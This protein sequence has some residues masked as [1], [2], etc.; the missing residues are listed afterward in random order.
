MKHRLSPAIVILI[1][2]ASAF[3][4]WQYLPAPLPQQWTTAELAT[5]QSL[6]LQQ[7]PP[8]PPDPSNRFADHPL[9]IEFGRQLFFDTRLSSN[10]A[11]SCA[12]CH[13]P[14]R[15]F[16]DGRA[17]A[18]GIGSADRNSMGLAG[19]AYSPWLFWDGRKDSLWSQA[20]EPLEN[21][22]EHGANRTQLA[23]LVAQ[24]HHYRD[25]YL[26]IFEAEPAQ[27]ILDQFADEM[28]FPDASP[29]GSAEQQ[30]AWAAIR[31][32]DQY[33]INRIFSNLGKALAAWQ[34]TL[35]VMPSA[36]DEYAAQL[37][38]NPDLQQN[39][40]LTRDAISGLRLFMGKAQCINCHNGPLFTNNAFHNT[41]V[42][43]APGVPPAA[44]RSQGLRLAQAD[45]FNCLGPY[46]DA[47]PAQCQE[48]RFARGGDEMI[49][50]QRTGSLRNLAYTAPY[51]HA[52]QLA[53]LDAVIEHYNRARVAVIGHN[54]AKPLALR[55]VEK[56]QLKA[57]LN[58]LNGPVAQPLS[59]TLSPKQEPE[60]R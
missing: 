19:A 37:T 29:N 15:Y 14:E 27:T 11:V 35:P 49:G 8:P 17:L 47:D 59:L 41:A 34:R 53:T 44:G 57:F 9:A 21:P 28:R 51:M 45:V 2:A 54:E 26:A 36:F 1:S 60:P 58:S 7:L 18:V 31:E 25:Q 52:G 38:N 33:H 24:D 48:L 55:A 40:L 20:L 50:A 5:L 30:Q 6:S 16:T 42:L 13:Q 46:S 43:S 12:S 56:R 23:R 4:A 22:V 3:A 39:T 10:N 32:E